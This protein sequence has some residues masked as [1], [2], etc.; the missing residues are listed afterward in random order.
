MLFRCSHSWSLQGCRKD[1]DII[2]GAGLWGWTVLLCPPH[3]LP[4]SPGHSL[5]VTGLK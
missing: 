2:G 5:A 4:Q 1:Y 3:L